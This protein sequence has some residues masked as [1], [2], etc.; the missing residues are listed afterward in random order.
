[1]KKAIKISSSIIA[2]ILAIILTVMSA[3]P[4]ESKVILFSI[5]LILFGGF[6]ISLTITAWKSHNR[7]N[8]FLN[9]LEFSFGLSS[10]IFVLGYLYTA[11]QPIILK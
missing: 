2:F 7:K 5:N 4:Y 8:T 3:P 1:M 9:C 11:L 10:L 6:V